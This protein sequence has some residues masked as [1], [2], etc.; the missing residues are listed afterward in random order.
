MVPC[1]RNLNSNN[2]LNLTMILRL[3]VKTILLLLLV[4]SAFSQV[5]L[6]SN[7]TKLRLKDSGV[8]WESEEVSGYYFF[9]SIGKA[10]KG[11]RTYIL[12]ILDENLQDVNTITLHEGKRSRI[13][14]SKFNG[15]DIIVKLFD[16]SR[17]MQL[18]YLFFNTKG[19]L[20]DRKTEKLSSDAAISLGRMETINESGFVEYRK[21][22]PYD[23]EFMIDYL[24]NSDAKNLKVQSEAWKRIFK[25]ND[26]KKERSY[27]EFLC[28]TDSAIINLISNKST[29]SIGTINFEIQAVDL[30]NG[31][32]VFR[33]GLN[34]TYNSQPLKAFYDEVTE[35]IN[36]IGL[37][38]SPEVKALKDNGLGLFNYQMDLEGNIVSRKNLFWTNEFRKYLNVDNKG[39]VTSDRRGFLY[40]HEIVKHSDGSIMAIAEQYQK[41]AD[42]LGIA[43]NVIGAAMGGGASAS[44]TKIQVYD[45]AIFHFN[46]DFTIRNVSFIPKAKSDVIL[47]AG[48]DFT[49]VH[50]L[51]NYVKSV[52][53][54]DYLYTTQNHADGTTSIAYLDYEKRSEES[55]RQW[56]FHTSTIYDGALTNDKIEVGTPSETKSLRIFPGKPGNIVVSEYDRTQ[57]SLRINY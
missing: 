37:F 42:G 6:Y 18:H 22:Y 32:Q 7:I 56:V 9:Y 20:I 30:V 40:F 45:M 43:M 44:T 5:R 29:R 16:T 12:N 49:N 15:K 24:P 25:P 35:L 33:K 54:F 39:M 41:V 34:D 55:R 2:F 19:E 14:E 53:G 17:S 4:N 28:T 26:P 31:E 13:L 3:A 57:K 47:P 11:K 23:K 38:Y 36:I 46:P 8:I 51:A 21:E 1:E 27:C 50:L 48:Y 10:V 52:D